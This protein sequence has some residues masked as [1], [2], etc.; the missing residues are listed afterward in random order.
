MR[1]KYE[2][3]VRGLDSFQK[4]S[5]SPCDSKTHI[6]LEV[7]YNTLKPCLFGIKLRDKRPKK[8]KITGLYLYGLS[9]EKNTG[10]RLSPEEEARLWS[11]LTSVRF[12]D[13]Q[14]DVLRI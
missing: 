4:S 5:C 14:D 10:I 8:P 6:S 7:D 2:R 9:N 11:Q 3:I 1:Y 12:S 13:Y